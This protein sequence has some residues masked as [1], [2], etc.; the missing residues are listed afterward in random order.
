MIAKKGC[1]NN[2]ID[3]TEDDVLYDEDSQ[4]DEL[5]ICIDELMK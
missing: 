5:D 4:D 2:T 1:I 3:R